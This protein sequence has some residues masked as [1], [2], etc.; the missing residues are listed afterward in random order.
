MLIC[1]SVRGSRVRHDQ[2]PGHTKDVCYSCFLVYWSKIL[3]QIHSV[4]NCKNSVHFIHQ[5]SLPSAHITHHVITTT[6]G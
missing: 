6:T 5:S 3:Q 4:S 2:V 1:E